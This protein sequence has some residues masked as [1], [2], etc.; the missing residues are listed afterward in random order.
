MEERFRATVEDKS[1]IKFLVRLVLT[2]GMGKL[3]TLETK[4]AKCLLTKNEDVNVFKNNNVLTIV[5]PECGECRYAVKNK[6]KPPQIC[7]IYRDNR[8]AF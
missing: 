5:A 3:I 4:V 2:Y 7:S 6:A 8:S 1:T